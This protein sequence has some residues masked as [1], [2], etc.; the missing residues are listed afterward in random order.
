MIFI[1]FRCEKDNLE[2]TLKRYLNLKDYS[3]KEHKGQGL[4]VSFKLLHGDI[5]QV[6]ISNHIILVK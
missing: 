5:K 2:N 6:D 4:S 1:L 3:H